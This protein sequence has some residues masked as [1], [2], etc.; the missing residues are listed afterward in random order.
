MVVRCQR[1]AQGINA[2]L[3]RGSNDAGELLTE[4]KADERREGAVR[5]RRRK[6]EADDAVIA[7]AFDANLI[8]ADDIELLESVR[9]LGVLFA[10]DQEKRKRKH[11]RDVVK[12]TLML[13][14]ASSRTLMSRM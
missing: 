1:H 13:M 11:I 5:Y 8:E 14:A 4:A 12:K 10:R 3:E 7:L 6:L 2:Y 9:V